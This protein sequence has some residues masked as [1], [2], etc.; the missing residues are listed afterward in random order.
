[1]TDANQ[2][3]LALLPSAHRLL[4]AQ[5]VTPQLIGG[6]AV[7]LRCAELVEPD[8]ELLDATHPRRLAT[9]VRST[10]DIDL[11][12]AEGQL[13]A[14]REALERASFSRVDGVRPPPLRMRHGRDIVDLI[15]CPPEAPAVMTRADLG[16]VLALL[17]DARTP[18]PVGG[19]ELYV[20]TREA[21]IVL[22]AV[23]WTDDPGREGDLVDV[24]RIALLDRES[25]TTSRALATL[26]AE[27]PAV[28]VSALRRLDGAFARDGSTGPATMVQSLRGAIPGLSLDDDLDLS[29]RDVVCASVRELLGPALGR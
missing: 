12:V 17:E 23:A 1:M 8:D 6:V 28:I 10:N 21:L 16:A 9:F 20:A 3:L 4:G 5:G 7:H 27:L 24:A 29:I 11:V 18:L 2:R 19:A 26:A 25:S 14:A 13:E 15:G 22:K